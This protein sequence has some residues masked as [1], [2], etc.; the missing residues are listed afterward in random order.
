MFR[1]TLVPQ[2]YKSAD[3]G[4]ASGSRIHARKSTPPFENARVSRHEHG[5]MGPRG[6]HDQPVGR[7]RVKLLQFRRRKPDLAVHRDLAKPHVEKLPA[8]RSDRRKRDAPPLLQ[9]RE[10]PEA[11]GTNG[12]AIGL[13]GRLDRMA[14]LFPQFVAALVEPHEDMRIEQHHRI[15]SHSV[16]S[17]ETMSPLT[18][19]LPR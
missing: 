5:I 14:R 6:G 3:L 2:P 8:P 1:V 12:E 13:E 15:A 9:H 10:L 4:A 18:T 17:G 7:I 11:D 16:S 19:I